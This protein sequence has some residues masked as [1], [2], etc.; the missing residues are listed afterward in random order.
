VLATDLD[1]TRPETKLWRQTNEYAGTVEA[2]RR[3][4]IC[5]DQV[6][7]ANIE[8]QPIDMNALPRRLEGQFDFCW[9]ACALEHLGSLENGIKFIENSLRMLK[10][11]GVAVHTTEFTLS[12]G[13]TIDHE[14]TVLY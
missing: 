14:P 11:G 12:R 10:P 8:F 6:L 13:D 5:P 2:L 3:S 4:D 9:S 7:L 1:S